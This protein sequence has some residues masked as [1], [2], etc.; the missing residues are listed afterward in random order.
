MVLLILTE[1]LLCDY[2]VGALSTDFADS[3]DLENI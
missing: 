3:D 1:T 2:T